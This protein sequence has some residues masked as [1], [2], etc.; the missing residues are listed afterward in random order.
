MMMRREYPELLEGEDRTRAQ[1]LAE[2]VR[3]AG[4]YLW[5]LRD[6][7]RFNTEFQSTPGDS[8]AYHAPCHLRAQAVGFRARNLLKKIPNVGTVSQV[9]EC[10]GHDGTY[11][12][13]TEGFVPS[14]RIGKRAFEGMDAAEAEIWVSDCPLAALQFEQHAG[15]RTMH[16][17]TV[18]ARAYRQDGFDSGSPNHPHEQEKKS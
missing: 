13:T 1:R 15:V 17:M 16:P 5:S 7:E 6:E 8:V 11:A 4:E 3:D 2:A 10:C 9:M 18:L 12:M 14:Q